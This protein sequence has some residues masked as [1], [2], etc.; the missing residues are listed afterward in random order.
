LWVVSSAAAHQ[1]LP[2]RVEIDVG[3]AT[4]DFLSI[5]HYAWWAAL[6]DYVVRA[7]GL[8]GVRILDMVQSPQHAE[9]L[10]L[11]CENFLASPRMKAAADGSYDHAAMDQMGA[12]GS[13][14]RGRDASANSGTT[15]NQTTK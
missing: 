2:G 1:L 6:L 7:F 10:R 5:A 8:A 11:W 4:S 14:V 15:T 3:D 9:R 12:I 13:A